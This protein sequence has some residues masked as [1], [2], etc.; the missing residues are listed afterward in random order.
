MVVF[1]HYACITCSSL[2]LPIFSLQF[3]SWV[4]W[5]T[6]QTRRYLLSSPVSSANV[7]HLESN[8]RLSSVLKNLAAKRSIDLISV[9][10]IISAVRY[11]KN[12]Q[13]YLN[14]KG[15]YL[16][17][18]L[19]CVTILLLCCRWSDAQSGVLLRCARDTN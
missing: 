11:F 8:A 6:V 4:T 7:N 2:K 18:V 10:R 16:E 9:V 19:R 15:L 12:L 13:I 5:C 14:K 17:E 1:S 3:A